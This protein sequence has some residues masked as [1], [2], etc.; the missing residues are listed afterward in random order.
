MTGVTGSRELW[1]RVY[2]DDIA[3]HTHE[4]ELTRDEADAGVE[5]WTAR[6]VAATTSDS[7]ERERLEQ[8][9]W[10]SLANAYGG[11]RASW[12]ASEISRRALAKPE[13]QD[14]SFLLVRA[15]LFAI[16]TDPQTTSS[17]KRAA[18]LQLLA[19]THPFVDVDPRR[20]HQSPAA[21]RRDHRRDATG[22]RADRERRRAH[23][24]GL[25]SRCVQARELEPRTAHR[26][27]C[28]TGSC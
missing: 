14:L 27:V 24:S 10:R 28:P 15:Q 26:S 3:V 25:R 8:G 16:L 13:N 19:S 6:A 23:V 9:A 5:Y 21:G 20:R 7:A 18:I 4:K 17:A 22:D 2:P 11:T 1:V 12:I